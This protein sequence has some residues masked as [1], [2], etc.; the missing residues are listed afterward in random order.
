M[1]KLA[2]I[3][4]VSIIAISAAACD[5]G[6]PE[7]GQSQSGAESASA[8]ASTQSSTDGNDAVKSSPPSVRNETTPG[9]VTIEVDGNP[10]DEQ[11]TPVVCVPEQDVLKID[12]GIENFAQIHAEVATPDAQPALNNLE[13]KTHTLNVKIDDRFTPNAVVTNDGASWVIEGEGVHSSDTN[14]ELPAQIRVRVMC[15]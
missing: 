8:L 4:I 3:S 7:F 2:A 12:G 6:E 1:K 9:E 5:S 14:T 15:P 11:F 13:I 10:V